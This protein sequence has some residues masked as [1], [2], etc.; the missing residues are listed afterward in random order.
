MRAV[1]P[2]VWKHFLHTC[3]VP[4]PFFA[5]VELPPAAFANCAIILG[6]SVECLME[7]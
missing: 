6:I 4:W 1:A 7:M 2:K 5:F 3:D